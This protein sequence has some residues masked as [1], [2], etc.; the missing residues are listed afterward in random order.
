MPTSIHG[1]TGFQVVPLT[2]D[3]LKEFNPLKDAIIFSDE[4]KK[5][6]VDI[7]GEFKFKLADEEFSVSSGGLEL[8]E[9]AA[10]YLFCQRKAL[11]G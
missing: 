6:T 4:P 11:I 9:Y 3:D 2:I 7:D 10:I 5:I 8:P 1:K